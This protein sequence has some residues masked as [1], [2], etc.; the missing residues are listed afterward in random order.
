MNLAQW[1][2]L[3]ATPVSTFLIIIGVVVVRGTK[4]SEFRQKWIDEQRADLA[5]VLAHASNIASGLTS[6]ATHFASDLLAFDLAANRIKLREKPTNP[7]WKEVIDQ[8]DAIRPKLLLPPTAPVASLSIDNEQKALVEKSREN[9]KAEWTR[10]KKGEF[11]YRLL[12]VLGCILTFASV[13]PLA[14][15]IIG[16]AAGWSRAPSPSDMLVN[17]GFAAGK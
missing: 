2:A 14:G 16:T 11:G 12:I 15:A 8:I 13:L 3:V 7:E 17:S 1:A 9:L 4:I 6:G 10:V 5:T